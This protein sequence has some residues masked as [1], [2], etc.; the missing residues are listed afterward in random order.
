MAKVGSVEIPV[1]LETKGFEAQIEQVSDELDKLTQE[2]EAI[3]DMPVYDTQQEDV[4]KYKAE[5]EKTTNKYCC[6]QG[7]EGFLK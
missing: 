3:K 7:L 6:K 1:E 5:I 4:L 2:Y